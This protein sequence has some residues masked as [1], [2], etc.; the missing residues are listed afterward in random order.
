MFLAYMFIE[1]RMEFTLN[2]C[3]N[4]IFNKKYGLRV[5]ISSRKSSKF[6]KAVKA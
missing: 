4:A 6:E 3:G 1:D 2:G 5:E